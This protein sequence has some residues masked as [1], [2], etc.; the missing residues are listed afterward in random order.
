MCTEQKAGKEERSRTAERSQIKHL[1]FVTEKDVN[2]Q[3]HALFEFC[4]LPHDK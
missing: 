1:P 4:E 3:Q 2:E